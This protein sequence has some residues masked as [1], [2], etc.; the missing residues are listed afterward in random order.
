MRGLAP[1]PGFPVPS[2][3]RRTRFESLARSIVFQQ[4]AWKAANSIWTRV[5][6]LTPGPGAPKPA[7][8]LKLS[9]SRLRGAG[10]S[11]AKLTALR[12][13][14]AKELEGDLKLRS[15][16]RSADEEVVERLVCV[17][18]IGPWTAQMFLLFHLGRLDV[19]PATD[20]GVQEGLRILDGLAERPEPRDVLERSRAWQPLCSVASWYLWRLVD[21]EPRS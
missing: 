15:M 21:A 5:R 17:R 14:A 2:E 7:E 3:R 20:L 13:L 10:L 9:E 18:G 12:D 4:L 19:M 8:V 6:A 11:R 16:H 1:F